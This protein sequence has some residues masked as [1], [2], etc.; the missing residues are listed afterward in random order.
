MR[1][2]APAAGVDA[3]PAQGAATAPAATPASELDIP[4]A[5]APAAD[6]QAIMERARRSAAGVD[7]ALR[8]ENHPVITAPLDSPQM[9]MRQGLEEAQALAQPNTWEAPKVEQLVNGTADGA[10][11]TRVITGRGTYCITERSPVTSIDMIEKHGRL[12]ITNCPQHESTAKR[13][14]WRTARD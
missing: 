13:Q 3:L 6:G 10:R 12:R 5:A 4:A 7:R 1:R 11:R 2:S 9:R 8:R 14:R